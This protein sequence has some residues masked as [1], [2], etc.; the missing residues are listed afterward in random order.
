MND[1]K[2]KIKPTKP[3]KRQSK[4]S[5]SRLLISVVSILM[6]GIAGLC[7]V[8]VLVW[9]LMGKDP[10]GLFTQKPAPPPKLAP[11][12]PAIAQAPSE[13]QAT[14]PDQLRQRKTQ[15]SEQNPS[16]DALAK[17]DDLKATEIEAKP[18]DAP[19]DNSVLSHSSSEKS[20]DFDAPKSIIEDVTLNDDRIEIPSEADQEQALATIRS[21]FEEQYRVAKTKEQKLNLASEMIK[22]SE[23]TREDV[24]GK[25]VLLRVAR[26]IATAQSEIDLTESSI[27]TMESSFAVDGTELRIEAWQELLSNTT[28]SDAKQKTLSKKLVTQ[29][30]QFAE[31][32]FNDT[33]DDAVFEII[34]FAD[35]Q[36]RAVIEEEQQKSL[37]DLSK[38]AEA[39]QD[40]LAL[41]N[42]AEVLLE[43]DPLDPDANE[44]LGCYY[45]F[46]LGQWE[47]GL[48]YL[49]RCGTRALS[50]LANAE[51]R[52]VE[53]G[54][55]DLSAAEIAGGW[56]EYAE[57]A[58]LPP[59]SPYETDSC[60]IVMEHS[61]AWYKRSLGKSTGL[62]RKVAETR[63]AEVEKL[64]S[65]EIHA[66]ALA[67]ENKT[68]KDKP[69]QQKQH[70]EKHENNAAK[71][72]KINSLLSLL[73]R[74][75]DCLVEERPV[76][77]EVAAAIRSLSYP[78]TLRI[79]AVPETSRYFL[80]A[81]NHLG[82]GSC[83]SSS[84]ID[85]LEP[86]VFRER[87]SITKPLKIYP[88]KR[89]VP[90]TDLLPE[91]CGNQFSY[92]YRGKHQG[93]YKLTKCV[94]AEGK[95]TYRVLTTQK[96]D[97]STG[98]PVMTFFGFGKTPDLWLVAFNGQYV[99]LG[100]T[101]NP[102]EGPQYIELSDVP[103]AGTRI[104][105]RAGVY[106]EYSEGVCYTLTPNGDIL[107]HS[108]N[109]SRKPVVVIN[110]KSNSQNLLKLWS[111]SWIR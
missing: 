55:Y 100:K 68:A 108:R 18:V 79:V 48:F 52:A 30:L 5:F 33:D 104:F 97:N 47:K 66:G 98:Y 109:P 56:W 50:D 10:F 20:N 85:Q 91:P 36:L 70:D 88:V 37:D 76:D 78:E 93:L 22:V 21:L 102:T 86:N 38:A 74:Y 28:A 59:S 32:R 3:R 67:D 75:V 61:V 65:L 94:L 29:I 4:K 14:K 8:A 39:R 1:I 31:Q 7:I 64:K 89:L 58:L 107:I 13:R 63:I 106:A 9:T 53:S 49:S 6:G 26:D 95:G 57:R 90:L 99:C 96:Y 87:Y 54:S 12:L 43:A 45:C 25:Y 81:V 103:G 71:A 51:L 105:V 42:A 69:A 111:G 2:V 46:H 72:S 41:K 35:A 17:V 11:A 62:T 110:G 24:A 16:D 77:Q 40:L 27:A 44:K 92:P 23:E 60:A 83:G 73:N 19:E 82:E 80:R 101:K 34:K 84:Q 15:T